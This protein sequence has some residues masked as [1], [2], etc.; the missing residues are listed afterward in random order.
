MR[1][2]LQE[3][4]RTSAATTRLTR[5]I[6]AAGSQRRKKILARASCATLV[7]ATI[8][9][10]AGLVF[11]DRDA[12]MSAHRLSTALKNPRQVMLVEYSGDVEIARKTATPE[13]ISRLRSAIS[14]WPRPFLP[15]PS[16]CFE[17]HHRIEIQRA[18]GSEWNTAICFLCGR[19]AIEE[20][21]FLAP[22][23]HYLAD[24]LGPF[25][26]SVG[27]A[28]KSDEEYRFLELGRSASL[29]RKQVRNNNSEDHGSEANESR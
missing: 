16:L 15:A 2:P 27:M 23:P 10:I 28:P 20:K 4:S 14:L 26:A 13:E 9:I 17:P 6:F 8:A 24:T 11:L 22:L 12:W 1:H 5:H 21:P 3:I 18:D 25:F 7:V 29:T 19:F